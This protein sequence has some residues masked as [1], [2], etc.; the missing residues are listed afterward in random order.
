VLRGDVFRTDE[1][2]SGIYGLETCPR[3]TSTNIPSRPSSLI[4]ERSS[5]VL[6]KT[7]SRRVIER[8][9]QSGDLKVADN[10]GQVYNRT[11]RAHTRLTTNGH[12]RPAEK[13]RYVDKYLISGG[14][15]GA[16]KVWAM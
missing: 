2:R 4:A 14:R 13:L 8:C 7:A 10:V 15:D 5:L 12:V 11:T 6:V 3:C 9:W 1:V 16:A